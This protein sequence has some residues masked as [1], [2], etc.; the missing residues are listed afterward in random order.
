MFNPLEIE[1]DEQSSETCGNLSLSLSL[2]L[3]LSLTPCLSLSPS[4]LTPYFQKI[5]DMK[6]SLRR[7][8][9]SWSPGAS[10]GGPGE[11][12]DR[13]G[14]TERFK[15]GRLAAVL[16]FSRT[17]GRSSGSPRRTVTAFLRW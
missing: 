13:T 2:P 8:H 4:E 7:N 3:S 5:R 17:S 6:D 15:V 9:R 11:M 1:P 14:V 10:R 12:S 16:G